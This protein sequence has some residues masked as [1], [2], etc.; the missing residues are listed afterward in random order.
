MTTIAD[1][2]QQHEKIAS[3]LRAFKD[4]P[5]TV[6]KEAESLTEGFN[7]KFAYIRAFEESVAFSNQQITKV[8]PLLEELFRFSVLDPESAEGMREIIAAV[9]ETSDEL[10]KTWRDTYAVLHRVDSIRDSLLLCKELADE[11]K[12][13]AGDLHD[14]YFVLPQDPEVMDMMQ[15]MNDL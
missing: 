14:R 4:T 5:Q 8:M 13:V 12:E 1:P 11:L 10:M 2:A 6:V 7:A 3:L 9:N 15:Q